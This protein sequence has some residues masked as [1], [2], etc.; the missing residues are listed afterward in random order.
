[1]NQFKG[2]FGANWENEIMISMDLVLMLGVACVGDG[3]LGKKL[4]SKKYMLVTSY[5]PLKI[6]PRQRK[7]EIWVNLRNA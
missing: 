1:M 3:L 4:A 2:R 7:G 5:S 6:R